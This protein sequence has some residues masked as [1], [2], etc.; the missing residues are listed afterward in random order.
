MRYPDGGGL[1]AAG[2]SRREA[3]R[4]QAATLLDGG[5]PVAEIAA[6]LRVSAES[7]YRWRR[8]WRAGGRQALV[9]TGSSGS[10]CRLDGKQLQRLAAMLDQ[11][12]VVHGFGL[13]QRWTLARIAE[14]IEREFHVSYTLRG[15]SY[16]LHRMGFTPQM[17]ARRAAERDPDA[18]AA[19]RSRRWPSVRG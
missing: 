11:G 9:S 19:W 12:P 14:L 18:I 15:T 13:D 4:L 10:A 5:V 7:V 6:R 1:T 3:V 8:R 2:R 16:L 17:P